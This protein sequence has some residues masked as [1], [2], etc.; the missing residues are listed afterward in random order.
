M[1]DKKGCWWY[2]YHRK[3]KQ[4]GLFTQMYNEEPQLQLGFL[5]STYM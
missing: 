5:Y 4:S 2:N 1:L 3:Q